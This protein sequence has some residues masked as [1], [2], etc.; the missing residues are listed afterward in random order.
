MIYLDVVHN[1]RHG[2]NKNWTKFCATTFK[3]LGG[4]DKQGKQI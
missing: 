1:K 3:I 2:K 4:A